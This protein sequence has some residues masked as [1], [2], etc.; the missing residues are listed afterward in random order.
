MNHDDIPEL[1][2]AQKIKI[3]TAAAAADQILTDDGAFAQ[4]MQ[5]GSVWRETR[6]SLHVPE[7]AGEYVA[8]LT[9]ILRR[10]P[11]GWG[12]WIRCDAGWYPMI[13]ELDHE[14]A[15]LDPNYEVHQVKEKFGELRYYFHSDIFN[16]FDSPFVDMISAFERRSTITC[17]LCGSAGRLHASAPIGFG[18]RVVKTL[19]G[20]CAAAG[21]RGRFYTP[22]I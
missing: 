7:D 6:D 12:R 10:I 22:T 13:C 8:Q 5:T 3:R 20:S 9:A 11:E 15:Q 2:E 17:E 16:G 14:L 18:S 21:D 1:T 19:C 4:F